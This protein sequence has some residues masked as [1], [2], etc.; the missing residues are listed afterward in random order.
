[1][2]GCRVW[3]K[4]E[5]SASIRGTPVSTITASW[6]AK[7]MISSCLIRLVPPSGKG[8]EPAVG[9][10]AWSEMIVFPS[11]RSVLVAWDMSSAASTPV[12]MAPRPSRTL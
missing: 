2:P 10:S 3:A 7:K 1:M 12:L 11:L 4:M 9:K 5:S 8:S 6:V